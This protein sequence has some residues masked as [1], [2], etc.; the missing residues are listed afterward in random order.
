[1]PYIKH[2]LSHS[3]PAG[4][5]GKYGSFLRSR[6]ALSEIARPAVVVLR[7]WAANNSEEEHH[8]IEK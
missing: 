5:T 1:M 2:P 3:V 6:T 4:Y 7:D 8:A